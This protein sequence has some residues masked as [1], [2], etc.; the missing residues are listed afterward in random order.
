MPAF[1]N[2]TG[3]RFGM[4]S[5]VRHHD[6]VYSAGGTPQHRWLCRCTCGNEKVV[7]GHYLRMGRT[8]S[9]GCKISVKHGKSRHPLYSTLTG[10]IQ[11]CHN[12]KS[13]AYPDYG[14]RGIKV[15]QAWREFPERFVAYVEAMG[16]TEGDSRSIDRIDNSGDY[17]P[18][19]IRLAS[20]H[21]QGRNK[22]SNI[23]LTWR[24]RT[25]TMVEW[26]EEMGMPYSRLQ[27]RIYRGWEP[28]RALTEP[29]LT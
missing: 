15:H 14:G 12:P 21:Q 29:V 28:E 22:R 2:L 18:G 9:C 27:T 4:L 8:V 24:G 13:C 5:V 11:R 6:K 17:R 16:W 26:A 20:R 19:N 25:L 23:L 10:M 1:K 7:R 3:E